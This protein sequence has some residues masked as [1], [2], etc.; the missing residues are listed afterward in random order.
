MTDFLLTD[1]ADGVRTLTLNRPAKRNALHTPLIEALLAAFAAA[2]GDPAIGAL[3]LTGAGSHFCAGA[4]LGEFRDA[5][6]GAETASERRSDLLLEL[7][8]RFASVRMPIVAALNGP[9]I[10]AGA[11]LA[12]AADMGVASVA[13]T[14]AYPETQHGMVPSLVLPT[15]VRHVGRKAAFEFATC[16][17][18]VP[19]ERALALGLLNRIVAPGDVLSEAQRIAAGLA[20]L[21]RFAITGTK[22]VLGAISDLP[23][24]DALRAGRALGQRLRAERL[25]T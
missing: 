9:A 16:G 22:R 11:A 23:L 18:P 17:A 21:D 1:D 12:L 5:G 10:G 2:D 3:V 6:A 8:L 4:D 24:A 13:A 19:A 15:L 7:Q 20:A 25:R 14:I